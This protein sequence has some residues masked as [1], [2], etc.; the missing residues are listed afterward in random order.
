MITKEKFQYTDGKMKGFRHTIAMIMQLGDRLEEL[1]L[2]LSG[3]TLKS[4]S[5][6]S[7]EEAK[8][9]SGTSIFHDNIIALSAEEVEKR[10]RVYPKA[11][12]IVQ[13]GICTMH[14]TEH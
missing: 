8:Y 12:I 2:T 7:P 4:P 13:H 5:I 11:P 6:K 9:Q 10:R 1:A 3:N 14:H